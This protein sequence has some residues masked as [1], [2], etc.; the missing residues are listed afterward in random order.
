M[1]RFINLLFLIIALILFTACAA[2]DTLT[3]AQ[4]EAQAFADLRSV[5]TAE[6]DDEHTRAD[7]LALL[8]ALEA[9]ITSMAADMV[10]SR[11]EIRRLNADY[12]TTRE[13]MASYID[14]ASLRMLAYRQ[15]ITEA[16][17]RMLA[18]TTPEQWKAIRKAESR[19]AMAV[20]EHLNV[21]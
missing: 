11:N 3:P 20:A 14:E 9:E 19:A 7:V 10:H 5:I 1:K 18:S 4:K 16:R 8:D 17:E 15:R 12:D 21:L 2:E 13:E 6:V